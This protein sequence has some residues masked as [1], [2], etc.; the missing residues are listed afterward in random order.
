MDKAA[1]GVL[2]GSTGRL[3]DTVEADET[4]M[5]VFINPPD[6]SGCWLTARASPAPCSA[7]EQRQVQ[8][9]VRRRDLLIVWAEKTFTVE[10]Y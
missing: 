7:A 2:A 1:V 5:S 3:Y 4:V 9:L 10:M 6:C 8:A